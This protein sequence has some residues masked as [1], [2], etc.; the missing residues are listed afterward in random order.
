M[1]VGDQAIALGNIAGETALHDPAD[2]VAVVA[3]END[4][5][6]WRVLP[7]LVVIRGNLSVLPVRVLPR[8]QEALT[9][10]LQLGVDVRQLLGRKLAH[11]LAK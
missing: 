6:E 11:K 10:L 3:F 2:D 9:F 7:R 5:L 8:L 1:H 4:E